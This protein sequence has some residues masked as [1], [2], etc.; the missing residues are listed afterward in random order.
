[1]SERRKRRTRRQNEEKKI[2]QH[3]DCLEVRKCEEQILSL[4]PSSPRKHLEGFSCFAHLVHL[5]VKIKMKRREKK[6]KN[7]SSGINLN[8]K[9]V[10]I[11]HKLMWMESRESFHLSSGSEN[12]ARSQGERKKLW[13]TTINWEKLLKHFLALHPGRTLIQSHLCV[14]LKPMKRCV[15]SKNWRAP[16]NRK[17]SFVFPPRSLCQQ[18]HYT[19]ED[20]H[21][22]IWRHESSHLG[23]FKAASVG[24]EGSREWS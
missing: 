13:E 8:R 20:F 3:E 7:L 2:Q 18:S 22:M 21:L 17:I 10:L 6:G 11:F 9:N 15:K 19:S 5:L 12:S 14:I 16:S 4:N 24:F 23:R 1:M